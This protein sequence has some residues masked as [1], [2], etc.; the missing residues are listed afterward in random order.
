MKKDIPINERFERQVVFRAARWL[1]LGMGAAAILGLIISLAMLAYSFRPIAEVQKPKPIPV[2]EAVTLSFDQLK[3]SVKLE[4]VKKT[5][6]DAISETGDQ[7]AQ[8]RSAAEIAIVEKAKTY[9]AE[10]GRLRAELM[11]RDVSLTDV[12]GQKCA[13]E[14][15]HHCYRYEETVIKKGI[16]S[17]ILA[18]IALYD[19]ESKAKFEKVEIPGSDL[20]VNVRLDEGLEIKTA[21]L[22]EL[23]KLIAQ[24]PVQETS[25]YV[26]AWTK[27]RIQK[28][29]ERRAQ[30]QQNIEEQN[31]QYS[32]AMQQY[33]ETE[34]K[35]K[36]L[37]S[38][39]LTALLGALS[40]LVFSGVAL[41]II[42][43]ERHARAIQA[44]I[45][46]VPKPIDM[47]QQPSDAPT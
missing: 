46:C 31:R 39:M 14:Y 16:G 43:I 15:D 11:K 45:T 25:A 32:D 41:A 9:A 47:Q 7:L 4:S 10:L 12:T 36:T 2:P 27:L 5:R 29:R 44:L 42:A 24:V 37:R 23:N 19:N 17:Q 30:H 21:V 22:K 38:A 8:N 34:L 26:E 33:E 3:N 40:V 6:Q 18:V 1:P 28:E 20:S 13:F 35:N